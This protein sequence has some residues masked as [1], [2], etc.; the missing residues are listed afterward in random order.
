[1]H[2]VCF[3]GIKREAL[4]VQLAPAFSERKEQGAKAVEDLGRNP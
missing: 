2:E 1:M 3:L 4:T